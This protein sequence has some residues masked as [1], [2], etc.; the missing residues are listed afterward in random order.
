MGTPAQQM[1][2]QVKKE[3]VDRSWLELRIPAN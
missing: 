3:F 2:P 1:Q